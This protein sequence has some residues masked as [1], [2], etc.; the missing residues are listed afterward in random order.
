M[1]TE[2]D[3][4]ALY[5]TEVETV[6]SDQIQTR[7][8]SLATRHFPLATRHLSRFLPARTPAWFATKALVFSVGGVSTVGFLAAMPGWLI[9]CGLAVGGFVW[10]L[11][12]E[13]AIK[14]QVRG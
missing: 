3:L 9:A 12:Y 7:H 6:A 5:P 8:S 10:F 2:Y 4:D 13:M 14:L 1:K 11:L